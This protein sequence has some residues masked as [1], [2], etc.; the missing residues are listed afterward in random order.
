[1]EKEEVD[2]RDIVGLAEKLE[3]VDIFTDAEI[4]ALRLV[5]D[6]AGN[7]LVPDT[8]VA[9]TLGTLLPGS[10]SERTRRAFKV[11]E[12]Y[13]PEPVTAE[14]PEFDPPDSGPGRC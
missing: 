10:D 1:M 13:S 4:K 2:W 3:R 7:I 11:Y 5:F 14:P 9:Q 8:P 6:V 12:L